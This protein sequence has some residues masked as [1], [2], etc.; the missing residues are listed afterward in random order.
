MVAIFMITWCLGEPGPCF[1]ED[2]NSSTPKDSLRGALR[3]CQPSAP[4]EDAW[5]GRE[6]MG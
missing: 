4:E 6:L 1:K 3:P 2:S 5:K